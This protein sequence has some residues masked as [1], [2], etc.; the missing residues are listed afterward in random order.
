MGQVRWVKGP[1]PWDEWD[2]E[3][4]DLRIVRDPEAEVMRRS[5]RRR[6]DVLFRPALYYYYYY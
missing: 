4:E 5:A 3:A 6:P 2:Y 1:L